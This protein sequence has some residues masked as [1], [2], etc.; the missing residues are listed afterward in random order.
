MAEPAAAAARGER[1]ERDEVGRQWWPP[2]QRARRLVG[3]ELRRGQRLGSPGAVEDDHGAQDDSDSVAFH[4]VLSEE[5]LP[6]FYE[7]DERGLPPRWLGL[8][9]ASLRS[10]GPRFSAG[11]MLDEY[12]RASVSPTLAGAAAG[13]V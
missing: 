5:V 3:R 1:H 12:V 10:I 9:R 11:R 13:K 6:A 4:R 2:A 8:M 7:R